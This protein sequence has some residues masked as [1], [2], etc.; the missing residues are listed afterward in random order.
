[1][2]QMV[3]FYSPSIKFRQAISI[4]HIYDNGMMGRGVFLGLE[5]YQ[6]S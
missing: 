5:A 2:S 4:C 1:M 6:I 3:F